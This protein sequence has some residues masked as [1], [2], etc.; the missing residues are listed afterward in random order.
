MTEKRIHSETFRAGR[1]LPDEPSGAA[2]TRAKKRAAAVKAAEEPQEAGEG[3]L[4][5][6]VRAFM[7]ESTNAD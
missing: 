2:S 1:W 4:L 7:E 6:A 5:P 3:L